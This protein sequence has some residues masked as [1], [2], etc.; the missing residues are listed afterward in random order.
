MSE[1]INDKIMFVILKFSITFKHNGISPRETIL[2]FTPTR[3][4]QI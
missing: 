1:T 3:P 4:H 2:A